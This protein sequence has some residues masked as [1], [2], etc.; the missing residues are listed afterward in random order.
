ME[1][2]LEKVIEKIPKDFMILGRDHIKHDGQK[3]VVP[4]TSEDEW[5]RVKM[6]RL[7]CAV[8]HLIL[9]DAEFKRGDEWLDKR[10]NDALN[11]FRKYQKQAAIH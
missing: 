8:V 9:W 7:D 6:G 5:E 2:F 4:I 3:I 10:I 1:G 11:S